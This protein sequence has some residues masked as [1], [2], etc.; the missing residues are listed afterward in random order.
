[1]ARAKKRT[2]RKTNTK[3]SASKKIFDFKKISVDQGR[4]L[5]AFLWA[6]L[7]VIGFSLIDLLVQYMNNDYS[8][9]VVNGVRISNSSFYDRLE[10]NYGAAT[11]ETLIEEELIRQEATKQGYA[12]SEEDIDERVAE[13]EEEFG[14]RDALNSE[15]AA[16]N[17]TREDLRRQLRIDLLA[18]RVLEPSLEY[19]QDDVREFFDQYKSLLYPGEED[20]AFEDK[21]EHIAEVY[22]RE[23]IRPLKENWVTELKADAKVQNNVTDKPEYGFL[24]V[25]GNIVNN[26]LNESETQ[27]D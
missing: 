21:Q 9:A 8:M 4:V 20:V 26:L 19:T 1:M 25:T 17:L 7:F 5:K 2:S 11:A 3:K 15:L 22:V 18:Q 27:E 24:K 12:V 6:F 13:L 14:G 16:I 23:Q 10:Q